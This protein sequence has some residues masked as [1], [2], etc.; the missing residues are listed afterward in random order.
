[1]IKIRR[2][3]AYE[4]TKS[5]ALKILRLKN[6]VWPTSQGVEDQCD[7]FIARSV[8]RPQREIIVAQQDGAFVAHAEI[9]NRTIKCGEQYCQVGCLAGVCVL[10]ERQGEGLGQIVVK[11][12]FRSLGRNNIQVF[13][14]Q[15]EVPEFYEK[16]GAT[17]IHNT[18][19]NSQSIRPNDNPWWDDIVMVYPLSDSWPKGVIDLNG[20][21]Y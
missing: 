16:L 3:K 1:M 18:F 21:A 9:F 12:A 14:F 15:T 7:S 5:L 6:A 20:D 2:I 4:L 11:E 17:V 8:D 19:I 10:P 13:L